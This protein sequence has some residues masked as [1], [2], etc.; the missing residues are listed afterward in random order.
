MT[1]IQKEFLDELELNKDKLF[2]VC[3][4]YAPNSSEAEDLFQEVIL[5]IWRSLPSFKRNSKLYTWMYRI[6][7]NVSIRYR[8]KASKKRKKFT[9]LNGITIESSYKPEED[10]EENEQLIILRS[11]IK[12]LDDSDKSVITLYLEEIPY[13]EIGTILGITENHVAVKVKRIKEKL[14]NCINQK[15]YD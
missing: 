1:D 14:L 13:K 12:S 11:C 10:V 4:V 5:Q 3:S 6:A 9:S 7:L 8:S 2:R 15:N